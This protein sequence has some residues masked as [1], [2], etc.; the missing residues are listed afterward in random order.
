MDV[1]PASLDVVTVGSAIVDVLAQ[2]D[3]AFVASHGLIKGTMVLVDHD[4]SAALYDAMPAGI[5]VSGGSAANTAA[6]IASLGGGVAFIGKVRDDELG[7]IFAHDLRS[8]GV[9]YTTPT[10]TS[11]PP[12]ARCLVLITPDAERTMS[13]YLGTASEMSAADVDP[14]LVASAGITYVEGYLV[15]LPSAE[16]ALEAAVTAA[17]AAGRK[18]ALT[19]S[20]P[21][22]VALQHDAF[23]AL[24]PDVDILLGNET[25]GLELTGE[26]SLEAAAAILAQ[27][28]DVVALTRGPAG[29]IATDGRETVSVGAEPVAKVVDTTGAGDLF[30]AGFLL[31]FARARPLEV[32]LRLGALAAA[33]VISHIGARPQ[34]LLAELAASKGLTI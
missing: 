23:K 10:G 11:G 34:T 31:G 30:A 12:T 18:V 17:H 28:V 29:A 32:C 3:D 7:E 20:D 24:L 5:E 13:T 1:A 22:W 4:Q 16:G 6:G 33:E 26:S 2:T 19:L 8:T 27:S 9:V 15:G 21:A 14:A 25:E